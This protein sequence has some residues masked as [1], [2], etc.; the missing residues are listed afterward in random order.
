[1]NSESTIDLT[2]ITKL[3]HAALWELSKRLGG[4]ARA[5]E[6][7]FVTTSIFNQWITLKK[8]FPSAPTRGWWMNK[9]RWTQTKDALESLTGQTLA[10]LWP[11]ALLNVIETHQ[12]ITTVEQVIEVPEQ[13]LLAYAEETATRFRLPPP[14][15]HAEQD[16]LRGAIQTA[17]KSLSPREREVLEL[18]YG[19]DGG[20][21]RSLEDVGHIVGVSR[22]R[23]RQIEARA[24]RR[25]TS[26]NVTKN[27]AG[28]LD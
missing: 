21:Q 26:P 15:V 14:V 18:R 8:A 11:Q 5:A 17:M 9:E 27:L 10:Q 7:C 25:L 16:E 22:E 28:F 20:E 4:Q 13:A 6:Q 24:T 23:V 1:M 3:R 12:L 19:L 2:A